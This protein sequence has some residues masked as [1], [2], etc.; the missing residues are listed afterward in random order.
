AGSREPVGRAGEIVRRVPSLD[1]ATDAVQLFVERAATDDGF[2]LDESNRDVVSAICAR[3]DGI[4]L[5]IELAAARARA[6]TPNEILSRLDDRFRLLRSSGRGGH[7][8]HQ[9]LLATVMW[10]VQLL[11]TEQ[12][13]LFERLSVFAHSFSL[14]DAEAVAGSAP[15]DP[16]EV[17]DLMSALVDRSMV[18]A[19]A[20]RDGVTR[21]RL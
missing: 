3:L 1:P 19:E 21:Y 6:L 13:C 8:R 11:S 4:P 12:R 16:W 14:A 2:V 5:A 18:I 9:T 7:E 17:V 15:L 20:G 10:S